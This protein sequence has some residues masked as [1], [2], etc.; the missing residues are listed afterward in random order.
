MDAET[1]K[2]IEDYFMGFELVE[3]LQISVEEVIEAFEE[4]ILEN[5][6]EIEDLIG[7]RER[8]GYDEE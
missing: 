4:D 6:D 5:L 8:Q 2:R 7:V 3:F 1:R